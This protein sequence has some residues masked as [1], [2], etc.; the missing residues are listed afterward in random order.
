M[1][2]LQQQII[3]VQCS[4]GSPG[5]ISP[6]ALQFLQKILEVDPLKR[7]TPQQILMDPWMQLTEIQKKEV[8]VF[9]DH[10]K[11]KIISEFQYYNQKKENTDEDKNYDPFLEQMLQTT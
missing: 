3:K 6:Q 2:E 8:E 7:L 9:T 11:L 10:E 4:W 1:I 5:D